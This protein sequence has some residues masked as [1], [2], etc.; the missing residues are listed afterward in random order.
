MYGVKTLSSVLFP[1]YK[2]GRESAY[3]ENMCDIVFEKARGG[4]GTENGMSDYAE[5]MR[6]HLC[7]SIFFDNIR[8]CRSATLL[9]TRVQRRCFIVNFVNFVRTHF[10][11]TPPNDC[12]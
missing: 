5:V 8:R 6:K 11:R 9:K 10:C 2:L 3:L 12:L 1:V 4:G 7:R